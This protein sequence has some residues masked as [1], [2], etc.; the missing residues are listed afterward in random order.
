MLEGLDARLHLSKAKL[1]SKLDAEESSNE[2][3]IAHAL[4]TALAKNK[5]QSNDS[6]IPKL[7]AGEPVL[8]SV[9]EEAY[10]FEIYLVEAM[11]C[12]C[13]N[14]HGNIIGCNKHQL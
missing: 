9:Y 8:L 5:F 10:D 6:H 11:N 13:C 4:T 7:I 1:L 2:Y 3:S 12:P 14:E